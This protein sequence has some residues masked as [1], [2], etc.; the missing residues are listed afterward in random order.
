[1]LKGKRKNQLYT[2]AVGLIFGGLVL[3]FGLQRWLKHDSTTIRA[4]QKVTFEPKVRTQPLA[5]RSIVL[6]NHLPIVD[7]QVELIGD[8]LTESVSLLN[9]KQTEAAVAVLNKAETIAETGANDQSNPQQANFQSINR[10]LDKV[11][12]N[13]QRGEIK[14][15]M[16]EIISILKELDEN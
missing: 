7:R 8:E 15:S 12:R 9:A 1:M 5:P 11:K 4:Q 16:P 2:A 3:S 13:I 14:E 10:R 6:E